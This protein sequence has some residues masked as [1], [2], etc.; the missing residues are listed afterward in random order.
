[1]AECDGGAGLDARGQVGHGGRKIA[2]RQVEGLVFEQAAG[3]ACGQG[4]HANRHAWGGL[5]HRGQ[6]AGHQLGCGGIGHGQNKGVAGLCWNKLTGHQGALELSKCFAH[7]WPERQR[8][9]RGAH[10]LPRALHQVVAQCLAQPLQGVADRRLR[11]RQLVGCAGQAAFG[12]D[13]IKHAQQVEVQLPKGRAVVRA[14]HH[15]PEYTLL[16]I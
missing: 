4:H 15:Q 13:L 1:M 7:R 9:R 10:L 2:N 8:A 6:Q 3:I 14:S 16:A 11:E 12:H 5:V